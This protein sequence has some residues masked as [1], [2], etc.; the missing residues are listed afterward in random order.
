MKNE[1]SDNDCNSKRQLFTTRYT[2]GSHDQEYIFSC[3]GRPFAALVSPN[4]PTPSSSL[5]DYDLIKSLGLKLTDLQCKKFHFAGNKF[6]I[7]GRVST[8]V[9]CIQNGRSGSNFHLKGFV[10]SDLYKVLDTHC[11]AGINMQQKISSLCKMTEEVSDDE[12]DDLDVDD[13][14]S[15]SEVFN[16]RKCDTK[17]QVKTE[18]VK[19]RSESEAKN[20]NK[21]HNVKREV[22]CS[23]ADALAQGESSG[24]ESEGPPPPP[25]PASVWVT[26]VNLPHSKLPPSSPNTRRRGVAYCPDAFRTELPLNTCPRPSSLYALK[27]FK[28]SDY[29]YWSKVTLSQAELKILKKSRDD[30]KPRVVNVNADPC[31]DDMLRVGVWDKLED[32]TEYQRRHI[33][34]ASLRR[35]APDR[36]CQM[37]SYV[38]QHSCTLSNHTG[39]MHCAKCCDDVKL[40]V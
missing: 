20:K 13:D 27:H 38:L 6:R 5:L 3:R 11:V 24:T 9:Q 19:R 39:I 10:I 4:L 14:D 36:V 35:A 37:C 29:E 15:V 18:S 17:S 31:R 7:L 28:S 25:D 12:D 34:I 33:L 1:S 40:K 2:Y 16:E 21:K 30:G 23:D 26:M 22:G 32:P 8:S